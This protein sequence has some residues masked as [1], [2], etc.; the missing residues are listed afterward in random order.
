MYPLIF[1]I[2]SNPVDNVILSEPEL[3]SSMMQDYEIRLHNPYKLK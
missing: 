3:A 2:A 1:S